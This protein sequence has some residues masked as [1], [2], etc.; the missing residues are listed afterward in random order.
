[1]KRPVPGTRTWPAAPPASPGTAQRKSRTAP[2]RAGQPVTAREPGVALCRVI[3]RAG[4]CSRSAAEALVRAGQVTVDGRIWR[5]PDARVAA[6]ARIL[7]DGAPL[8]CAQRLTIALN[9]PRGLMVTAADERGRA[10]VFSLLAGADLPHLGPVG[11]LDQASEGL[12]LL[13][14][15]TALAARLT[16]PSTHV[17]K[18][19]HV[20]IDRLADPALLAALV[21]GRAVDG[22]WLAVAD[23]QLLR[24]GERHCWLALTLTEGRNR[25]LRRLLGAFGIQVLRLVRVAIGGLALGELGKGQWR[26]LTDAELTLLR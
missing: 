19:Y 10:T 22:E 23:A 6:T 20:Q 14:N 15:D 17:P 9:K 7:I 2:A 26:P 24:A 1:M 16:D 21:E 5:D 13:S 12:L 18:T 8:Q 25:H 4:H 3:N 11:R